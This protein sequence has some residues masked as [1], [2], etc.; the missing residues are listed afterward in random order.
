MKNI[1][2]RVIQLT[3]KKAEKETEQKGETDGKKRK[4]ITKWYVYS[5]ISIIA[6][7]ANE[8]NTPIR[9]QRLSE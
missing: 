5:I 2:L 8:L 4:Q 1:V 6:L 3:Q 9:K 7:N